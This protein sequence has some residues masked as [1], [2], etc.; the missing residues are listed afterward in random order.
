MRRHP[1]ALTLVVLGRGDRLFKND[2]IAD[3]LARQLGELLWVETAEGSAD[4]EPLS[5]EFPQVRFL[6]VTGSRTPGD[7]VNIGIEEARAP[8]V[9]VMWSDTRLADFPAG[10]V[11]AIEKSGVLCTVPVALTGKGETV[12]SWQAPLWKSRRF[13]PAYHLPRT[14]GQRVLYPFDYCGLY[15]RLKFSQTGGFDPSVPNS[16]WQKLDFGLRSFLW[17]ERLAGTL[18]IGVTYTGSLPQQDTTPDAGYKKVWLKNLA[19]RTRR[20][21]GVLPAWRL[22]DYMTHSD[23]GPLVSVKEFRVARAW[24]HRHRFRFRRDPRELTDAWERT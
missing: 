5:R 6:L 14:E 17:G 20:E 8:L 4:V 24:V 12:P 9:M 18:K 1:F 23:T 15:H 7:R 10:E 11:S 22:L 16:Y 21:M 13:S 3:L 2:L 19:V